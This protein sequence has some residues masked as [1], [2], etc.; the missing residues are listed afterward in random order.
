MMISNFTVENGAWKALFTG[1]DID[2]THSSFEMNASGKADNATAGTWLET[3]VD[4]NGIGT[5]SRTK[6]NE[7]TTASGTKKTIQSKTE[8]RES[9]NINESQ[10]TKSGTHS[11]VNGVT[12]SMVSEHATSRN[13]WIRTNDP[14]SILLFGTPGVY[15]NLAG[16]TTSSSLSTVH[17]PGSNGTAPGYSESLYTQNILMTSS[18]PGEE[19]TVTNTIRDFYT[20]ANVSGVAPMRDVNETITTYGGSLNGSTINT[21]L[22]IP[23]DILVVEMTFGANGASVASVGRVRIEGGFWNT[24]VSVQPISSAPKPRVSEPISGENSEVDKVDAN[25]PVDKPTRKE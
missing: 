24:G 19:Y 20:Y 3:T 1:R 12:R 18:A 9:Q 7:W 17:T 11:V 6:T 22:T 25:E 16:G 21:Y 14:L 10:T 23:G 15:Q 2:A 13:M 5:T 4:R 8:N